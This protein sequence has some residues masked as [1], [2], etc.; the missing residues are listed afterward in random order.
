MMKL[1]VPLGL[2]IGFL[3]GG[4]MAGPRAQVAPEVRW[5]SFRGV[6]A[7][8]VAE[9]GNPPA[10]WDVENGR[11]VAW[12]TPIPGVGHSSPIVWGDR[13]FVTT[14]VMLEDDA[15]RDAPAENAKPAPAAN[16]L[17]APVTDNDKPHA[18]RLY[19][20]DRKDGRVLWERTAHQGIPRI[21][22]HPKTTHASATPASDGVHVVAMMGSEG[23]YAYDFDGRQLWKQDLGA[24]DVGLVEDPTDQ[25][26]PAS[27]P[28]IHG[29]RVIVQNDRHKNSFVAPFDVKTGREVWRVDRDE[30]PAWS[31]PVVHPSAEPRLITNSPHFIRGHDPETGKELWRVPAEAEVKV[32]TPVIAGDLIIVTGGWPLGGQP[33]FGIR[34]ATGEVEWKVDRGSTYTTTPIVYQGILCIVADNGVLAAYDVKTGER[35]YQQRIARDAGGFSASPVAAAGRVYFT[36][37]DGVVYVARAGKVFE[38][39]ARNDMPEMCLATPAITG[40]ML[41]VRTRGHLYALR[42]S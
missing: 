9:T 20:L 23:L 40:D 30:L 4:S 7:T 25:W 10:R 22:R 19:C 28:I 34:A 1:R 26:G 29:G 39:L 38:L 27:S 2:L 24:L 15:R 41:I 18:W 12:T 16:P 11:N 17:E 33:I 37:E 42:E 5:P 31:T 35:L 21:K 36:S 32:V 8:G 13:V 3:L 14:A 6:D